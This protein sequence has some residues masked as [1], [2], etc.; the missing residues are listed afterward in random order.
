MPVAP[1]AGR[2]PL[3]GDAEDQGQ[4]RGHD[5]TGNDDAD[6]RDDDDRV[7]RSLIAV[8]RPE[9]AERKADDQG[10][11]HGAQAQFERDGKTLA[12]QLGDTE[13]L[14]GEGRP[15]V[16]LRQIA[17]V[18]QILLIERLVQVIGVQQI[19]LHFRRHHPPRVEGPPGVRRIIR[20]VR[21][22]MTNNVG[23]APTKRF[24]SI[25]S[26]SG[27]RV[28]CSMRHDRHEL[29]NRCIRKDWG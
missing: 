22:M 5:K 23:M 21:V 10:Q 19:G 26:I 11:D 17:Q 3:Q 20:K 12:D 15:E 16:A 8:Q 7:V 18:A 29:W 6:H 4:D 24:T 14:A 9:G 25:D 27:S 28:P 13:V 2:Q 1:A